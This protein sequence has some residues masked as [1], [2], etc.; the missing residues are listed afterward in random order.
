MN[1]RKICQARQMYIRVSHAVYWLHN[2]HVAPDTLIVGV[3]R[4]KLVIQKDEE[5]LD[6]PLGEWARPLPLPI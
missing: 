4:D 2:S 3:V 6:T 1:G 5:V